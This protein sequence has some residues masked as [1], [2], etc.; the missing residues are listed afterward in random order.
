MEEFEFLGENA[1]FEEL[2][3]HRLL[4]SAKRL[5]KLLELGAPDVIIG[6]EIYLLT[7]SAM[8]I[9]GDKFI[10]SLT[11]RLVEGV[12]IKYGF[13]AD[14][15]KNKISTNHTCNT[16]EFLGEIEQEKIDKE[17]FNEEG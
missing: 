15:G 13:C 5:V 7:E 1:S 10:S 8:P 4:R 14:C 2:A 9:Y 3:K 17:Y 6:N 12:R 16:C 11:E